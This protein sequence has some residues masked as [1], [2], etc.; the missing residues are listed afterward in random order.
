MSVFELT[1][2]ISVLVLSSIGVITSHNYLTDMELDLIKSEGRTR[3]IRWKDLPTWRY[4]F[5]LWSIIGYLAI[6]ARVLYLWA[7]LVMVSIIR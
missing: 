1:L 3:I 4:R 2:L 5:F 7:D 6:A